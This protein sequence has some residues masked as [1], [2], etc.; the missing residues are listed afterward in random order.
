M[1]KKKK[2]STQQKPKPTG[3]FSVINVKIEYLNNILLK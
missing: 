2:K 1:F 3:H